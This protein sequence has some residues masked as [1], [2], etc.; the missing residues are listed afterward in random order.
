MSQKKELDYL[1]ILRALEE[2]P[3]SVGK[4]LLIDFIR[5]NKT[6]ESIIRN[7]LDRLNNFGSL[8]YE[9]DELDEMIESLI[10]N[11]MIRFSSVNGNRFWKALEL[12]P[13][14]MKE[15]YEPKLFKKKVAFNFNETATIITD[16]EK[17]IFR[18]LG[19]EFEEY[20]DEQKKAIISNKKQILCIA[21]A[22][23]GKTT[24]LTK[25]IDFLIKYRSVDPNRIL[26]I[27]FTRKARREMVSRLEKMGQLSVN[28]ET[29]NSF[30]EQILRKYND[31]V[32]DRPVRVIN[33]RDKITLVNT[34]LY[35]LGININR[36]IN[37]YFT[38]AQ[39][40]GKT[41]EQLVNIFI[42]DCFFVRDYFK[43]KHKQLSEESF[44]TFD[45]NER[46]CAELVFN[47]CNYIQ[48]QMQ[49]QGLRDFADQLIDTLNF[50]NNAPAQIPKFDHVLVDE[51]QDVNSTQIQLLDF[52]S[53]ENIFCVGD[54]RQ[55]I[56]GWRGSDIRYILNFEEKYPGCDVITLTKNYRSSKHIVELINKSV[57]NMG[58]ANLES[59]VEGKKD[60]KLLKFESEDAEFEFVIQRLL[61]ST[62]PR[63]DVF[64]LARTNRQL[65][66]LSLILKSRGIK[67]VVRS[68]EL[69]KSVIAGEDDMT[70]AT[71]HA[72][73]GL[74]AK[75]VFVI[76]C[77]GINFPCKSSDHP[78]IDMIK[79]EEYDKEEEERRLF[80]VAMSRARESLYLTYPGKKHTSFINYDMLGILNE[81]QPKITALPKI[82][83]STT[84]LYKAGDVTTRLKAWRLDLSRE[85]GVP[86]FMILHD[87]TLEDIVIKKPETT[88]ELE[89][90]KGLGPVKIMK[91]GEELLKIVNL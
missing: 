61:A 9:P 91:Y 46:K 84:R 35:K 38:T 24:V 1:F 69:R 62:V 30:C 68:D 18:S 43:F 76:G 89:F 75:M 42:N 5:G 33:Y 71:V 65:N 25:R 51:Y 15:I 73:K 70:L 37:I 90:I 50:F 88:K 39:I 56:Y 60:V 26:A 53:P 41:K 77:T 7:N 58:F 3:F 47:V 36:A 79:V 40:R 82:T 17:S 48:L 64:V 57:R 54:P 32:Y 45:D 28:I 72:I 8:A 6:N 23:S 4:K 34:A 27:T 87:S 78:V 86:A 44:E 13:K 59:C 19:A 55:S 63:K 10:L 66:E 49:Q 80:Y 14:G 2:I 74:E 16:E 21:G 67:H 29:F 52:L 22:G 85:L 20:N 83:S 11:D 81:A 12:S 31:L